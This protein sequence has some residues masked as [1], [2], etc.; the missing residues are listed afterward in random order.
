MSD[1]KDD[2]PVSRSRSDQRL[3]F[4]PLSTYRRE[5]FRKHQSVW[6][7]YLPVLGV[8]LPGL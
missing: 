5:L 1:Y 7:I 6:T 4:D 8:Q 3:Y 2:E